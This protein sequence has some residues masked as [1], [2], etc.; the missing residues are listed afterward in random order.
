MV[1]DKVI[2]EHPEGQFA[3]NTPILQ[4]SAPSTGNK[5]MTTAALFYHLS[6]TTRLRILQALEQGHKPVADLCRELKASQPLVSHHLA[7]LRN[8]G[9]VEAVP[10]GKQRF[11]H[12]TVLGNAMVDVINQA[13]GAL[14]HDRGMET[15]SSVPKL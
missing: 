9:M 4:E 3:A 11:Y 8:T 10:S 15:N 1:N 7:K 13:N 12:L 14:N 6:D 2:W 5:P